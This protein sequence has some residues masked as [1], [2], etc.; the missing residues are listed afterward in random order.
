[1]HTLLVMPYRWARFAAAAPAIAAAAERL[2]RAFTIGYLATVRRDG[3]PR[4]HPVTVTLAGDGLYVLVLRHTPKAGDLRR[5]G[6]FAL[7]A[8]PHSP[9]ADGWH[10]EEVMIGGTAALVTDRE[11]S[12]R[13]ERVHNDTAPPDA[14]LFELSVDRAVHKFRG[15]GGQADVV[16]FSI[17]ASTSGASGSTRG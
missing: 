7:H 6:R 10:D 14:L 16:T 2:F 11:V 1:V 3:A 5:D 9:T 12:E 13:V 15:E 17:A 4:V 8:F